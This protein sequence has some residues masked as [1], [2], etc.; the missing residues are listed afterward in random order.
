M[1]IIVK[2]VRRNIYQEG[3]LVVFLMF[4][5]CNVFAHTTTSDTIKKKGW[6]FGVLPAVSFDS[7]LGFQYGGLVDA[8]NYGDGTIYPNYKHEVYVEISR[9]TK[10]SGINRFFYNSGKS[11]KKILLSLDATYLTDM[12]FPFY[13]INGA[14]SLYTQSFTDKESS[15][16]KSRMFY[17]YDRKL[18]R[19]EPIFIGVLKGNSKWIAGAGIYKY[20]IGS[21]NIDKLN[22]GKDEKDKLPTIDLL[23]DLYVKNGLIAKED[24]SGGWYN[25]LFGGFIYD[26][27]NSTANPERGMMQEAL[28]GISPEGAGNTRTC[29]KVGLSH[30]QFIPIVKKRLTFG[31]RLA[32]TFNSDNT[33]WY[34]RQLLLKS[35]PNS[36]YSEGVGGGK[37]VRGI[38]L[39]RVIGQDFAYGNFEFRYRFARTRIFKQNF[40]LTLSSFYDVGYIT[41]FSRLQLS[42]VVDDSRIQY[43]SNSKTDGLHQGVGMGLRVIMN[44][45]FIV[46]F[47]YGKALDKQ[48]GDTGFY[49]NLNFLF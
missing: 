31:Y 30:R 7:D 41:R 13:G 6:N 42:D 14:Q 8:F 2:T 44:E 10:G 20:E 28:V 21:V 19:V 5:G 49:I 48:D 9:M 3:Y 32:W 29:F 39:Y 12:A 22:K 47:D 18:M 45:N 38:K 25:H 40:Y 23:Y 43:F 11:F 33:P 37:T 26:T 34:A 27:R 1:E 17:A 24:A 4:L 16:Y 35:N 46:A 15:S 36:A